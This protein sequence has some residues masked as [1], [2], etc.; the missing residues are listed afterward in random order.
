MDMGVVARRPASTGSTTPLI[1]RD[2]SLA[3]KVAAQAMSHAVPS[4]PNGPARLRKS[5]VSSVILPAT[6]GV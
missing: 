5:R 1:Q 4:V 3:R 2:S 6:I